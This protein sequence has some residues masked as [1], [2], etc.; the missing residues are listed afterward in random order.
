V[1][2]YPTFVRSIVDQCRE[3]YAIF[4]SVF[5]IRLVIVLCGSTGTELFM[6]KPG[7]FLLPGSDPPRAERMLVKAG[8][9]QGI[10]FA[11]A[12][13]NEQKKAGTVPQSFPQV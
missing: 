1:G 11:D 9:G 3:I 4:Q 7:T 5:N 2:R 13:I 10:D 12:I 6:D 8:S